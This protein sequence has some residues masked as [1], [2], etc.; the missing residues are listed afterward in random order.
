MKYLTAFTLMRNGV[1]FS[2][3]TQA[4]VDS[5]KTESVI[6]FRPGG[7]GELLN[8]STYALLR[9][10]LVRE[11]GPK[12]EWLQAL[13]TVTLDGTMLINYRPVAWF[14]GAADMYGSML[15]DT[16]GRLWYPDYGHDRVWDMWGLHVR[17]E[18]M[19]GK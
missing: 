14:V 6:H 1:P 7:H 10:D 12:S 17:F 16:P 5:E 18:R 2:D 4:T 11:F 3:I 8:A 19:L 15:I 9:L 13:C